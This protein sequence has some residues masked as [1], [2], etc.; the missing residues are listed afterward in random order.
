MIAS[1]R[2]KDPKERPLEFNYDH[3]N[4]PKPLAKIKMWTKFWQQK[5]AE[6]THVTIDL[7]EFYKSDMHEML[8]FILPSKH[9]F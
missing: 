7:G 6:G 8:I 5:N 2:R 1:K 3:P 4:Q 9:G